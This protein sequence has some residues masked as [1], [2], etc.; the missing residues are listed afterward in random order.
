MYNKLIKLSF[1]YFYVVFQDETSLWWLRILKPGFRHCYILIPLGD[2]SYLELNPMSNQL[3]INIYHF[4]RGYDY[5]SSLKAA[6]KQVVWVAMPQYT[7]MSAA[8]IGVFTCVEFVKRTLGLHDRKIMT[9]YAL[10]KYLK[11]VGKSS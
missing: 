1:S 5:I 8:P 9:P 3:F 11:V 2:N 10:Y 4:P 7:P 6:S